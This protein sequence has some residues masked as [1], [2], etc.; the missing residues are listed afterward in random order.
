MSRH[1]IAEPSPAVEKKIA[2]HMK[3]V[4]FEFLIDKSFHRGQTMLTAKGTSLTHD[5]LQVAA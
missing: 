4:T 2:L 1:D 5:H 3:T